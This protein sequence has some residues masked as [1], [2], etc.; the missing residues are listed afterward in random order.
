MARMVQH[1]I[2]TFNNIVSFQIST[3]AKSRSWLAS[4]WTTLSAAIFPPSTSASANLALRE[5]DKSSVEVSR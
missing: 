5:T 3:S 2:Q 4:A 1:N